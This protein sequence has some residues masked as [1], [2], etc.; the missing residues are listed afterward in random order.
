MPVARASCDSERPCSA[1]SYFSYLVSRLASCD[2]CVVGDGGSCDGDKDLLSQDSCASVASIS[3][4][5]LCKLSRIGLSVAAR[6]L[7]GTSHP[8]F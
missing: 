7:T 2:L 3:S 6:R 4:P 8:I 5:K 1:R